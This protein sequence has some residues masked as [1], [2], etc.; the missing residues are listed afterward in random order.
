L[1]NSLELKYFLVVTAC[2][3]GILA[4]LC[5]LNPIVYAQPAAQNQ[6]NITDILIGNYPFITVEYE[7]SS[8]VVIRAD[9]DS[10]LLA[11]GTLAPFWEA[12]DKAQ[13]HGFKLDDIATSGMGSQANPTRFYAIMS[14]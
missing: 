11:N 9:E 4:A 6:V 8:N 3:F 7:D 2:A 14:K 1:A 10:L 13:G 5:L 12:I